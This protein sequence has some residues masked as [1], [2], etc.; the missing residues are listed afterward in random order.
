M[1]ALII[2]DLVMF[3]ILEIEAFY[4][5]YKKGNSDV[6]CDFSAVASL[7]E[8]WLLGF[9][10]DPDPSKTA[11]KS[12]SSETHNS[13]RSRLSFA[14]A[15]SLCA[16]SHAGALVMSSLRDHIEKHEG[17]VSNL[18]A[19]ISASQGLHGITADIRMT[20][21]KIDPDVFDLALKVYQVIRQDVIKDAIAWDDL[22]LV[23]KAAEENDRKTR[24]IAFNQLAK[25]EIDPDSRV[26]RY[27][28]VTPEDEKDFFHEQV[29]NL[30]IDLAYSMNEAGLL[31]RESGTRRA[32]LLPG[33]RSLLQKTNDL[34]IHRHPEFKFRLERDFERTVE[35]FFSNTIAG[36]RSEDNGIYA[37]EITQSFLDNGVPAAYIMANGPCHPRYSQDS[38]S[39]ELTGDLTL[40]KAILQ[41]CLLSDGNKRFYTAVY[42]AY[43]QE[44]TPKQI[45][46]AC[47]TPKALATV[48]RLTADKQLL[49]GGNDLT[50]SLVMG[51]D[52]GL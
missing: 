44:F 51:Q 36:I 42:R 47:Q 7:T 6:F 12:L 16:S 31:K 30:R 46:D 1:T 52:L 39:P 21:Q 41:F 15:M 33:G 49:Q 32:T 17:S 18:V 43:L 3:P 25:F 38:E 5:E 19:D 22:D 48:Y 8:Q 11:L 40:G 37:D 45:I 26:H 2:R 23:I 29:S 9:K 4:T 28:I 27:L 10:D 34:P 13:A 35:G 50:R 14:I 20:L 24:F